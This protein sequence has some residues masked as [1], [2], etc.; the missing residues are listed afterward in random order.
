MDTLNLDKVVAVD[1]VVD[2]EETFR[3]VEVISRGGVNKS[4]YVMA[5]DSVS[6]QALVWNNI[7]PPSLTTV[8]QRV[9]RVQYTI[10]VACAY[11]TAGTAAGN[12]PYFGAANLIAGQTGQQSTAGNYM[13]CCLRAFPLQSAASSIE[14]RIN[15]NATS[16]SPNDYICTLPHL[17]SQDELNRY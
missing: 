14:V 15:G 12:Y 13:T 5:A 6:S 1:P 10:Q 11:T 7:T 4:V 16:T 3:P 17:L 2:V 9:L 8:V